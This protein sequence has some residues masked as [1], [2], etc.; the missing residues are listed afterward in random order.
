MEEGSSETRGAIPF[1]GAA[2]TETNADAVPDGGVTEPRRWDRQGQG[3][4]EAGPGT[5]R[6]W[7]RDGRGLGRAGAGPGPGTGQGLGRGRA[8]DGAG[9]GTGQ[10]LGP[11]P[12]RLRAFQAWPLSA[13]GQEMTHRGV[14]IRRLC[15][16]TL[17]DQR[18]WHLH[19]GEPLP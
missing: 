3:R 11:G 7:N 14:L 5:G 17:R 9:P 19:A 10:G 16:P 2:G 4:G 1:G 8:W 13:G 18:G 15:L 12:P 6:A